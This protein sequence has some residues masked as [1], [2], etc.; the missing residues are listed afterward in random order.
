MSYDARVREGSAMYLE[1][2]PI[3]ETDANAEMK[4]RLSQ[5]A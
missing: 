3:P 1:S 4:A 2:D 5:Q